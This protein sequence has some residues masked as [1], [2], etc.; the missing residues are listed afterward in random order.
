MTSNESFPPPPKVVKDLHIAPTKYASLYRQSLDDPTSF[1]GDLAAK[2]LEWIKPFTRVLDQTP[3]GYHWFQGGRLNITYN[4]LDRH[5]KS[6]LGG[7]TAYIYVNETGQT[8][9]TTYQH[10]L[11]LVSQT[12]H[13]LTN[14]GINKGDTVT[15]Y[16]PLSL[17]QVIIML[18]CARIG[19]VHSV[20]YAGFSI[21]A[22]ASRLDD[23][24]S[25]LL[26]TTDFTTRRGNHINLLST[27]R[28]AR[29]LAS[30]ITRTL[31]V[32]RG[33]DTKLQSGELDFYK[34]ITNQP[35]TFKPVAVS[36][37]DPLFILYTSGTTGQPK[38]VVHAVAGYHLYTHF[39]LKTVFN[40]QPNDTYWCTADCGWITGHS[41]IVYGPLSNATTTLIYE[42]AP[43]YP[44]PDIWWQLIDK[45]QVTKFYTA[46]TAIRMFIRHGDQYPA[47]HS[48][49]SLQVIGSVGEPINPS[50]WHWYSKN[51]GK[52]HC[53]L[54]D[55]WWQ[56][57]TGGFAIATLPGLPQKPGKAGLPFFGILADVVDMEGRS[58]KVGQKGHLVIKQPWPGALKTCW[59]NKARFRQYWHTIG[60]FY[61]T[62]DFAIKDKDG[63]FQILG[64]SD[65]VISVSGHR[66]GS[67]EI[68]NTLVSHPKVTEAAAIGLPDSVTGEHITAFV[69]LSQATKPS[70]H[71]SKELIDYVATHY[72]KHAKP[73]SIE[74][75]DKLP[76]TRSGKIIRR[77][78][79][80]RA[81]GQDPG[82]LST[83]ED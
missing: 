67:A 80:A 83:L 1:W 33:A 81:L 21:D 13:T 12:A 44:H 79:K 54:V 74:F 2:E 23:A 77:L 32:R 16:M 7:K 63:Y 27:A 3:T 34:Q 43:D 30:T 20:V 41:Y 28:K 75:V 48:L 26:V 19:A 22:L 51:I 6:G 50:A 58:L 11:T 68:E 47:K 36:A 31:I 4:C 39:T 66:I 56:T 55:T 5:V 38:G 46:P 78:L 8:Q 18:A 64:R 9:K 25:R 15:V 53:V 70:A 82:D 59:R 72:G 71:L 69:T 60:N 73:K 57:E 62:G 24:K 49:S 29:K 76:K 61:S 45:H 65:D 37:S 42:G 40:L 10:L 14:L 52:N 17:E 35:K